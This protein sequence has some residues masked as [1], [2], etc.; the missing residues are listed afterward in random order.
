MHKVHIRDN[1]FF[2]SKNPNRPNNH[3]DWVWDTSLKDN[4]IT[5]FTDN[6]IKEA[7]NNKSKHKIAW[8]IEPP[9]IYPKIYEEIKKI[10]NNF[11]EVYTFNDSLLSIG[12]KFKY[13]PYGTCWI[14]PNDRKIY[15]KTKNISIIVSNKRYTEGHKLRHE[16]VQRYRY[17]MDVMGLGYKPFKNKVDGHRDYRYSIVVENS[18][19]NSYF[20]EKLLDCFLSGTVPIYWG[21]SKI[22]EMFDPKGVICFNSIDQLKYILDKASV[23]DYNSRI[24]AI[25]NNFNTAKK[26]SCLEKSLW[27]R[28][29][30]KYF[31]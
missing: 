11:D 8:L 17:R 19:V 13:M 22:N 16:I 1:N 9:S 10:H 12:P 3:F 28:E 15:P 20:S 31:S 6:F 5:I 18:R 2:S 21:F 26:Y 4:F 25:R 27:E 30:N 23:N 29:L 7:Q 14:A 24:G